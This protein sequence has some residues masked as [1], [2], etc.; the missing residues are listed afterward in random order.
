MTSLAPPTEAIIHL[1]LCNYKTKCSTNRYKCL[2][3]GLN[4]FEMC[5]CEKCENDV[6]YKEMFHESQTRDDDELC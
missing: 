4:C 3:N 5:R 1:T 6:K 2:K